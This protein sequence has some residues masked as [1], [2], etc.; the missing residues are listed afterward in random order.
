MLARLSPV[1]AVAPLEE[2]FASLRFFEVAGAGRSAAV[3]ESEER[4]EVSSWKTDE[5]MTSM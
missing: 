5:E 2:P 1:A 4:R 3:E